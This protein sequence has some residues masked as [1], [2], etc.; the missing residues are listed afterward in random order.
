M[1]S[2]FF[3]TT[4][5]IF[6]ALPKSF[7]HFF[8]FVRIEPFGFVFPGSLIVHVRIAHSFH[9]LISHGDHLLAGLAKDF[10]LQFLELAHIRIF[11]KAGKIAFLFFDFFFLNHAA[12]L[13]STILL[14]NVLSIACGGNP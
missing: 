10:L 13:R 3:V 5:G 8:Q 11:F 6:F 2:I 1:F 14:R 9:E 4:F 7:F 12:R